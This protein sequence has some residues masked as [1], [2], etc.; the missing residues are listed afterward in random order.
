M[1]LTV[2]GA[3][4][5]LARRLETIPGIT[6][7][8]GLDATMVVLPE[9]GLVYQ[10][11][12]IVRELGGQIVSLGAK[13]ELAGRPDQRSLCGQRRSERPQGHEGCPQVASSNRSTQAAG[14]EAASFRHLA[15][16]SVRA[17][18]ANASSIR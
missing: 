1:E 7:R 4:G 18:P 6:I 8:Q 9:Q 5:Q 12:D 11:I 13:R 14:H 3:N 15:A 16:R 10:A 17:N 2:H